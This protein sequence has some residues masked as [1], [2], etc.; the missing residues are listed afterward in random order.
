MGIATRALLLILVA[1]LLPACEKWSW[2]P[3]E[4]SLRGLFAENNER[5]EE[6]RR[7]MLTDGLEAVDS[8]HARGRAPWSCEGAGCPSTIEDDDDEL[9]AKYSELIEER[10]IFRYIF[11]D[12]DFYISDLPLPSTLGGDF[13]F[14]FVR[15]EDELAIPHCDE[16]KARLP[17]C[18][19]CYED[20]DPNWYMYWR[21]FPQDL[22]A[23][24]DGS[25]GEGRP[26]REEIDKQYEDALEDCLKAGWAEMGLDTDAD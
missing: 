1:T 5:F 11:R 7:N 26:T 17:S 22:G 14:D 18:G 13:Y 3:Y 10:S 4:E 6:I 2:P 25:V 20:L 12:N 8:A 9:Q 15:S 21:W 23:D 16:R 19:A 24:W